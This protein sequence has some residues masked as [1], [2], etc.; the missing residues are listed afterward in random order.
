M[1]WEEAC[2]ILGIPITATQKE[3]HA[4]YIYKAQLL[5]PDKTTGL[6]ESVRQKAEEELKRINAAYNVLKNIEGNPADIAPK[7]EI[8]PARICFKDIAPGEKKTATLSINNAG[9]SYTRFWID[10]APSTWL[11]VIEAKSTSEQPLPLEITLE[12]TGISPSGSQDTCNLQIKLEN[13][14]TGRVDE[15]VVEV[16]LKSASGERHFLSNVFGPVLKNPFKRT[17]EAPER[18][19]QWTVWLK[20]AIVISAGAIAGLIFNNVTGTFIPLPLLLGAAV[21][22]AVEKWHRGLTSK[23]KI[24]GTVYRI[25]LNLSILALVGLIVWTG[26]KISSGELHTSNTINGFLL[27][28]QLIVLGFVGKVASNNSWRRPKFV[29]TLF[30]VV[31]ILVF[32]AIVD[33]GPLAPYKEPA[34]DFFGDIIERIRIFINSN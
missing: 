24:I 10:D 2:Q 4:Q 3:I 26:L 6:P 25:I 29:P 20:S 13:E 21:F 22:F 31:A 19:P 12:A 32:L 15:S 5:H 23:F 17:T 28:L 14:K 27:V 33:T 30:L 11:K 9:G 1:N 18:T 34:I 16:E 7:L 8:S